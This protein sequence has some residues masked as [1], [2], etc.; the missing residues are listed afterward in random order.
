[1]H[2]ARDSFA[3]IVQIDPENAEANNNLAYILAEFNKPDEALPYAQKAAMLT[4]R[5][6]N[7]RDTLGWIHFQL[8]NYDD[9]ET[10]LL[11][12][13]RRQRSATVAYHL[14]EVYRAKRDWQAARRHYGEAEKMAEAASNAKLLSQIRIAMDDIRSR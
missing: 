9:A 5:D 8:A 1:M 6:S 14:G 12:S 13:Y 3:R 7:V 11:V 2:G 10:E 4:P